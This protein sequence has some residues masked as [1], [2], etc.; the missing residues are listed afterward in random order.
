[1]SGEWKEAKTPEGKVYYYNT[2]TKATS[3]KLTDEIKA[4][5]GPASNPAT[6]VKSPSTTVMPAIES[7]WK[8]TKTPDGKV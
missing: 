3:W 6:L 1:M 7:D 4:S 2:I 8:E 5:L